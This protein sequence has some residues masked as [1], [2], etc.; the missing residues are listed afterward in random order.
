MQEALDWDN[1]V[2]YAEDEDLSVEEA[3]QEIRATWELFLDRYF[4]SDEDLRC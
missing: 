1:I 4:D 3:E 2:G